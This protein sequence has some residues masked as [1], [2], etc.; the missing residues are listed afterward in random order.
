MEVKDNNNKNMGPYTFDLYLLTVEWKKV[1]NTDNWIE[2]KNWLLADPSNRYIHVVG[3]DPSTYTSRFEP[4]YQI[5]HAN[6]AN[7]FETEYY[8]SSQASKVV[9]EAT[10]YDAVEKPKHYQE[11]VPGMQY[12][13][14][15]QYMLPD[16]DSHL[17]GQIYKYLMRNGKKDDEAQELGK[18]LWYARFLRA[19]KIVN[20]HIK[21]EE[22]EGILNGTILN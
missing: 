19:R 8:W 22:V 1:D 18:V 14:M 6:D 7:K 4:Q 2:A 5:H 16:V 15:M 9:E 17:L 12:M 10:Q 11:I 3:M 13:E 21:Y 20:R